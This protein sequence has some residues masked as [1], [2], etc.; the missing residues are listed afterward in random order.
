MSERP[1][2]LRRGRDPRDLVGLARFLA[3]Y[4]WRIA[5]AMV[6]LVCA[7]GAV[8]ALGQGLKFVIDAGF[9]SRSM[10]QLNATLAFVIGIAVV[11]SVAS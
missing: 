1:F 4:R 8:L 10:S 5:A 2:A 9:G 7:A 3:P 6:A 11:M